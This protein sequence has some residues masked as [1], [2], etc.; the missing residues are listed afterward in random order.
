[1]P[2]LP[3]PR[4]R[5]ERGRRKWEGAVF[6]LFKI[7]IAPRVCFFSRP[8]VAPRPAAEIHPAH[9]QP[10]PC[11]PAAAFPPAPLRRRP[12][13]RR[14]F[15]C[16]PRAVVLSAGRRRAVPFFILEAW[17]LACPYTCAS[18]SRVPFFILGHGDGM[19]DRMAINEKQFHFLY[20]GMETQGA[21]RQ[22]ERAGAGKRLPFARRNHNLLPPETIPL[23]R[24]NVCSRKAHTRL[25]GARGRT[26]AA[27]SLPSYSAARVVKVA[28]ATG[29]VTPPS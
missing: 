26:R 3:C 13:C 19:R 22:G 24:Q 6:T 27:E 1:M 18:P 16:P 28:V 11:A 20:F 23:A 21:D 7:S 29:V 12:L 9:F 8:A 15:S 4:A 14:T 25:A 10:F 5:P 2:P 17:R